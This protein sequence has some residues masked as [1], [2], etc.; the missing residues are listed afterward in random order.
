MDFGTLDTP[1]RNDLISRIKELKKT[2]ESLIAK[3]Q[4][5]PVKET[6]PAEKPVRKKI[7]KSQTKP[8]AATPKPEKV[9][10]GKKRST[11]KLKK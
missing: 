2:A 9:E 5:A 10:D 3:I 1:A 6:A 4:S 7:V 8:A 11:I